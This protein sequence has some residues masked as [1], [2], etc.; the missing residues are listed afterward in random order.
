MHAPLEQRM[1]AL[2]EQEMHALPEQEMYALPEQGIHALPEQGIHALPEQGMHALPE[3]TSYWIGVR[4][5]R[6]LVLCAMFCRWLLVL[7][8]IYFWSL[9]CLPFFDLR[10][11]ITP[12]VSLSFSL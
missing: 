3:H 5:G 9:Y 6:S 8:S 10:L 12:L 7:L 11:L 2:P 1:H 4:I